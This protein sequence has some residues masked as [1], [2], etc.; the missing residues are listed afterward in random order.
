MLDQS[1]PIWTLTE[2]ETPKAYTAFC[3]YRDMGPE[4]SFRKLVTVLGRPHGYLRTIEAWSK[5]YNWVVRAKSY[6]LRNEHVKDD[7]KVAVIIDQQQLLMERRTALKET[8][9]ELASSLF[10]KA[11][12]ML[13]FPITRVSRET[14]DNGKTL[15]TNIEPAKWTVKDIARMADIANK[16]ARLSV[17]LPTEILDIT[18]ELMTV[19]RRKDIDL[20]PILKELHNQLSE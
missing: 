19:A 1:P 4:R 20:L 18:G 16:I 17:D 13:A 12:Q 3:L 15:I 2:G 11:R 10:E 5:K 6:D 9:W 14:K 7:A 8:G